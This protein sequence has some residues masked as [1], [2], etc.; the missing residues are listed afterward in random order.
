MNIVIFGTGLFYKNRKHEFNGYRI[1]AFFDNDLEKQGSELDNAAIISPAKWK[2]V[3]FD[4]IVLMS[5]QSVSMKMQLL[6]EGVEESKIL[7]FNDFL[8]LRDRHKVEVYY[9]DSFGRKQNVLIISNPLDYTGAPIACLYAAMAMRK[10]G[11]K[12]TI[13]AEAGNRKF[14]DEITSHGINVCI[15]RYICTGDE[16]D[17][18]WIR[19]F[20]HVI[21]NTFSMLPVVDSIKG[22][23]KP[24]VWIHEAEQFYDKVNRVLDGSRL[25]FCRVFAV[26][27]WAQ[28]NLR[29]KF[30]E[31]KSGILQY[32][33]VDEACTS[34]DKRANNDVIRIGVIGYSCERKAQLDFLLAIKKLPCKYLNKLQVVLVG[35][36]LDDEYGNE[37]RNEMDSLNF[38]YSIGSK[39][40]KEMPGILEDF[41][42]IAVPS[43]DDPLPIVATEGMMHR[44]VC[45]VSDHTGTASFIKD[46]ENGLIIKSGDHEDIRKHVMWLIDNKDEL[47]RI[48]Q[49]SRCVY[50]EFFSMKSF[51]NRLQNV[52]DGN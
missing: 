19:D 3:D 34:P 28:E 43:T 16:S 25:D 40:R 2:S 12:V 51:E 6:N 32:A 7:D 45:L 5:L 8:Y 42:V 37:L 1:V 17:L 26:S 22:F 52:L 11:Y 4:K 30:P 10:I 15:Y 49:K 39:S 47:E 18:S 24:I 27:T 33:I 31:V 9:G 41:D 13:A 20:D 36:I 38:C 50:D 23:C 44:K 29:K 46:R 48:G 35:E 14:I 21:V